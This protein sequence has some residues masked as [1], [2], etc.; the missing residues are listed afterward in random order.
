MAYRARVQIGAGRL[1][2]ATREPVYQCHT[3][4]SSQYGPQRRT[5]EIETR[6][7]QGVVAAERDRQL[8]TLDV[9]TDNRD[10]RFGDA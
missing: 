3:P 6:S 8:P 2:D 4:Q 10:N 7:H 1:S 9:F 5:F